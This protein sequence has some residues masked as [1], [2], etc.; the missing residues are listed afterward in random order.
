MRTLGVH[1]RKGCTRVVEHGVDEYLKVRQL[2]RL[3]FG[4][5]KVFECSCDDG[6]ELLCLVT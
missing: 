2:E 4:I 5:V 6:L 3:R 1:Q